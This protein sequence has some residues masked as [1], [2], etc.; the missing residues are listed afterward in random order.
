MDYIVPWEW[1]V[2]TIFSGIKGTPFFSGKV[3]E[4]HPVPYM[5]KVR[6]EGRLWVTL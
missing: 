4:N 1:E 3:L 5:L 2:H 6:V